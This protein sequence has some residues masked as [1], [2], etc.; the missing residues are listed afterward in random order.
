MSTAPPTPPGKP[1]RVEIVLHPGKK[2][3]VKPNRYKKPGP[4]ANTCGIVCPKTDPGPPGGNVRPPVIPETP[5]EKNFM[6]KFKDGVDDWIDKQVEGSGYSQAAMIAGAVGKAVNELVTPTQWWEAIPG[7]KQV[8]VAGKGVKAAKGLIKGEKAAGAAKDVKKASGKGSG[9][10]VDGPKRRG[11]CDHLKKGDPNGSGTYR[12]GSYGGTKAPGIESHHAPANSSSPIPR[13]QGPAIQMEKPDHAG[14]SSHG[15]QGADGARYR[16]EL[17]K[18]LEDGKWRDAMAM[19]IRDIRRVATEAG[20]PKK[21]NQAIKE[22]LAYFKCLE[23]HG[24][25]K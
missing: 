3:K 6:E 7:G 15:H 25:L 9:G 21:Y 24:L 11:P 22:M 5:E 14:T 17:S 19:E 4:N 2:A 23:K 1:F 20:D 8:K 13:S 18:M 10:R 16:A 12:G